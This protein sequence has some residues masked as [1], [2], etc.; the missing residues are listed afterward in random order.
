MFL[1]LPVLLSACLYLD[2]GT[3]LSLKKLDPYSVDLLN[4]RA[5][6]LIPD[7]IDYAQN[8]EVTVRVTRSGKVL[9]EE[10]FALEVV[11]NGE[12]LPGVNLR[13]LPGRPLVVRLAEADYERAITLQKRLGAMDKNHQ[14]VEPDS[15]T[16][17]GDKKGE[18]AIAADEKAS[19]D[20]TIGWQFTIPSTSRD[21][22]C[23]RHKKI[24]LTAWVKIN[25]DPGY[26]RVVH[27]LPLKRI[28]GRK[29][30][31]ALCLAPDPKP[32]KSASR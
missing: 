28:Y 19:G 16:M 1:V 17:T 15:D 3:V 9:R 22:Y 24:G 20:L 29:G 6:V 32:P 13:K 31:K 10:V 27:G 7:D 21:K 8:I 26:R 18:R 4:S 2:I 25:D 30:K 11:G 14:W 12:D 23:R 5:A